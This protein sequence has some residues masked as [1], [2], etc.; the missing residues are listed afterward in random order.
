MHLKCLMNCICCKKELDNF[1]PPR[2]QPIGGT[3]FLTYGHYGSAVTDNLGQSVFI[4]NI[5]DDCL[6]EALKDSRAKEQ[7]VK[8]RQDNPESWFGR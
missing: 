5:C 4:V 2:N 6:N 7:S 1:D 3:E 8:F